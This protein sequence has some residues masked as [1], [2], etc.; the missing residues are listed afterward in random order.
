MS[1]LGFLGVP[2]GARRRAL[3]AAIVAGVLGAGTAAQAAS[4]QTVTIGNS[5]AGT[6]VTLGLCF[7]ECT[8]FQTREAGAPVSSPVSGSVTSWAYRS[9]SVNSKYRLEILHPTGGGNYALSSESPPV[10]VENSEP[11]AVVNVPLPTP[12]AIAA[13]DSVAL[14]TENAPD[15]VPTSGANNTGDECGE[16]RRSPAKRASRKRSRA[17]RASGAGTPRDSTISGCAAPRAAPAAKRSQ[18]QRRRATR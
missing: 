15:G 16:C 7:S 12:L 10:T 17:R 2:L 8:V 1:K 6:E 3:I 18:E 5:L 9:G 11:S 14:H 4:A 13:G